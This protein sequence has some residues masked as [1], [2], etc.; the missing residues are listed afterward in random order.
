MA[1]QPIQSSPA[2]RRP[3]LATLSFIGLFAGTA[4]AQ[5]TGTLE[6]V[7]E[8]HPAYPEQAQAMEGR[9]ELEFTVSPEGTVEAPRVTAAE[10]AGVFDQA[11][12]EAVSRWRYLADA[13]RAPQQVRTTLSFSPPRAV[14]PAPPQPAML[15]R[16]ADGPR[17]QCVRESAAYNYGDVIEVDLM[18]ACEEPLL[19]F[20]CAQGTGRSIGRWVCT[21]SEQQQLLLVR[22]GDSRIGRTQP[23]PTLTGEQAY[24]HA[25]NFSV[26][27]AP[28][29]Q[30]WWVACVAD[31][32]AC[33]DIART[34]ARS[35]NMQPAAVN[36]QQRTAI[37]LA[38]SY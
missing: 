12:I 36:P 1:S 13:E 23:V 30:Y 15:S 38:R 4:M 7:I 24:S 21:D 14:G 8:V 27:R 25:D 9:V 32:E 18:S 19:V 34:W 31:D 16:R 11:A 29:S 20:G 3:R 6:P 5:N 33:R 26:S 22:P 28:N 17:N 2:R 35:V 10:P 37:A